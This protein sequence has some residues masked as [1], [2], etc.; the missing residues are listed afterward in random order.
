MSESL[1]LSN[2]DSRNNTSPSARLTR[3]E[4]DI[5]NLRARNSET[6]D[7][8][9]KLRLIVMPIVTSVSTLTVLS[10]RHDRDSRRI[11]EGLERLSERLAPIVGTVGAHGALLSEHI[12]DCERDRREQRELA[13]ERHEENQT[14]IRRVNSATKRLSHVYYFVGAVVVLAG[15]LFSDLGQR[16]MH[17]LAPVVK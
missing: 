9:D 6:W 7:E 2:G 5:A 4:T 16:L 8:I 15:F 17:Y 3:V 14:S 13:T 1:I 11:L 10:E 12:S